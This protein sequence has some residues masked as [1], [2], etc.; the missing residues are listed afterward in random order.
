MSSPLPAISVGKFYLHNVV[1]VHLDSGQSM[2]L[3]AAVE[4]Y[5]ASPLPPVE[6]YMASPL[7]PHTGVH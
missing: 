3:L 6:L 2:A 5:M 1:C 7:P 4:L